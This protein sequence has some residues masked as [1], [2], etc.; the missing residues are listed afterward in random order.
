MNVNE[1]QIASV[2]TVLKKSCSVCKN[3]RVVEYVD[4]ILGKRFRTCVCTASQKNLLKLRTSNIPKR[5]MQRT[6]KNYNVDCG[7]E[8]ETDRNKNTIDNLKLLVEKHDT[9]TKMGYDVVLSGGVS[10]GKTMVGCILLKELI[11]RHGYSG[12]FLTAEEL[13][14]MAIGKNRIDQELASKFDEISAVDFVMIDDFDLLVNLDDKRISGN[15]FY[16]LENFFSSRK[17]TNKSFI[18]TSKLTL[19]TLI[20]R[21]RFISKLSYTAMKFRLYGNYTR[22]K[23]SEITKNIGFGE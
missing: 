15:V 11:M 22:I 14:T 16:I 1:D 7:S 18:L 6:F 5:F 17:N 3:T 19:K 2:E 8:K 4:P 23:R 10:C 9:V 12:Y 21:D 13:I 20:E